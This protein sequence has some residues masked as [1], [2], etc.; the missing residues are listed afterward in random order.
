MRKNRKINKIVVTLLLASVIIM[1]GIALVSGAADSKKEQSKIAYGTGDTGKYEVLTNRHTQYVEAETA[2]CQLT[3]EG[4]EEKMNNGTLSVWY[5]EDMQALRI[6]DLRTGY[7]WG[8][9]DDKDEYKLNKKWT[10]R[11]T[12]LCYIN[13]F[14]FEGKEEAAALSEKTFK[15]KFKWKK[16]EFSC[17]VSARKLGIS[18]KFTGAL[19][20]DKFTFAMDDKSIKETGKS[21]L[22]KV[23]F[24]SFMGSVYE[25]TIPGYMLVP[26]GSGALIRFRKA[27]AYQSGYSRKVYGNDLAID[28]DTSGSNLNGNRTDDYATEE[29]QLSLPIWGMV[30]GENQN[31]ILA[32]IDSGELYTTINVIPAGAG[33]Q[34]VKF[35][36]AYADF[37]Y[38]CEYE[39]RVSNS[40]VVKVPQDEKNTINPKLTFTFLANEA[41]DYSGMAEIYRDK[42]LK[43]KMLPKNEIV[44]DGD[45]SLF[46]HVAGSEVKKGFLSNG[47][48][49][50]T[51][52]EQAENIVKKLDKEGIT[53]VSM[54]L[55]GWNKGGY[56]GAA[57]GSTKFE[58]KV[59]REKEIAALRD[60]LEKQGGSFSLAYNAVDAN[61]DQISINQDAA[62]NATLNTM[63]KT[64]PNQSLM[65]PNTYFLNHEMIT[66][67]LTKG[68]RDL[69]G[70]NLLLE[71]LGK[72]LYSDY[73]I[74]HEITRDEARA[75]IVKSIEKA[76]QNILLD[77]E[78]LYMVKYASEIIDMPLS[79]SQYIYETDSVPFL[80]MVLRGSVNYYSAYSNQGFYSNAS[81][82]KMIEY[83]AYP[84]FMVMGAD[85]FSLNDTPLENHFSLNYGDWED[86]IL[87][88]YGKVNGALSKVKGA[89][90]T[91]HNVVAEGVYCTSYDNGTQIYV[92]YNDEDHTTVDNIVIPAGGYKV[93]E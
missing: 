19:D 49:E 73:T 18:F 91:D 5:Q 20:E 34:T 90:I 11:A 25:D 62:L 57:F 23:S 59:G 80:Q 40:K 48:A 3:T 7:V 65:Y 71:D 69:S 30:H 64:I 4:F 27:K 75:S 52:A 77:A 6:V 9:I 41:A 70:Y 16:E 17:E 32:T 8:C 82:L 42:L 93:E 76:E 56:H 1:A 68:F 86:K 24:M 46:L 37:I 26:D 47:L 74:D 15:T 72:Y 60:M 36:R 84:S 85:N 81:V 55:S 35:S 79:G 33:N 78:N 10:A 50:L 43:E 39:K 38:R 51:T 87:D 13:Y 53:N 63:K 92:N 89:A 29:N 67:A 22:A 44:K 54:M 88:V 58:K 21:K 45:I 83:G 2:I 28:K 14:N 61:E 31:G 12:S 66:K